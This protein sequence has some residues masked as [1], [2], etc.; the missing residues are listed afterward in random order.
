MSMTW[1]NSPNTCVPHWRTSLLLVL[2]LAAG[3]AGRSGAVLP[4]APTAFAPDPP[5]AIASDT[6]LVIYSHGSRAENLADRC[7]PLAGTT[8]PIIR[9]LAGRS[10]H[11]QRL[12]V[13]AHCSSTG[14]GAFDARER[15]GRPKVEQRAAD[16]ERRVAAFVALGM[17]AERIVLAGHSAGGWISLLVAAEHEPRVAGAIAFAPAFAGPMRTRSDGWQWLR[18][19]HAE[20]L[21]RASRID[22]LVFAFAGD[23]FEG[24]DDLAFLA[25]I[26]GVEMVS[27]ANPALAGPACGGHSAHRTSFSPCFARDH[28]ARL[29]DFVAQRA[30][31]LAGNGGAGQPAPPPPAA[32]ARARSP[33][34]IQ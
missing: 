15:H 23:G 29:V 9:Q 16:L 30:A 13:Y 32:G 20:R 8:P 34:T 22:A 19:L 31:G 11:G 5:A 7:A 17:P 28:G 6:I 3:C 14:A 12:V 4:P 1:R 26:S 33:R 10:V 24:P 21:A 25:G 2:V 18:D 27:V